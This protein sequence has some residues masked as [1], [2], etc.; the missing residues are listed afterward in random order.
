MNIKGELT[1]NS[2]IFGMII[3]FGLFFAV[4]GGTIDIFDTSYDVSGVDESDL[5]SS[6]FNHLDSLANRLN[7]SEKG[8]S[9]VEGLVVEPKWYDWFAGLWN[10]VRS[11]L[12]FI[13]KSYTSLIDVSDESVS[14]LKLMPEFKTAI[15]TII[16][17]LVVFGLLLGRWMLGRK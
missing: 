6:G 17:L 8:Y 7:D 3:C 2:L 14:K 12:T 16:I 10:N 13:F 1:L 9:A 4:I 5:N 11:S 15:T